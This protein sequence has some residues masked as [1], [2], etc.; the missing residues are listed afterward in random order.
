MG[1]QEV[2]VLDSWNF[3][4]SNAKMSN[5]KFTKIRLFQSYLFFLS[6]I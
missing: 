2:K 1:G 4:Y 6:L 5:S 3:L